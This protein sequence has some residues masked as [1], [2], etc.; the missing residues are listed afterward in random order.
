MKFHLLSISIW[1]TSYSICSKS[2]GIFYRCSPEH[3]NEFLEINLQRKNSQF[4]HAPN[5]N[6]PNNSHNNITY[7]R[8]D[9]LLY[10]AENLLLFTFP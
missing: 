5:A 4:D 10:F 1:D 7:I 9:C 2:V 6:I 8:K 3:S